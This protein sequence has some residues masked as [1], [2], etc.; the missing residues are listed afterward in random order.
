MISGNRILSLASILS[1]SLLLAACSGAPGEGEGV[2]VQTPIVTASQ[3]E[4]G[5]VVGDWIVI[6]GLSDPEA[7]NPVTSNDASASEIDGY[8]YETLTS[9]DVV[10]LKSIPWIADSLPRV[11][12]DGLSYEFSIR[13]DARFSD[14]E[15]VTAED[16]IFHL[17]TIKNP[18]ILKA[19]PIRGYYSRVDSASMIDG[20]PLKLRVVMAE[21]YYLGDQWA[22][23]LIAYPKHIWDPTN[24]SDRISFAD[25]NADSVTSDE[26]RKLIRQMADSIE[27]INKNF[28]PNYIVGSG[29]Y[30]LDEF[31]A[32]DRVALRRNPDY[33]NQEHRYG[34]NWPERVMWL[35]INDRNAALSALKAG[36]IDIV[37]QLDQV[38]FK[39]E[40]ER[41]PKNDLVPAQYEYPAYNYVGYNAD[42]KEKPFLGD[43]KVRLAFA[44]ALDREKMIDK[45]FFG[46]AVPVQSPIYRNR[47]EYDTTLPFIEYDLSETRRLLDEAGW[48]D[49]DGDGVRDKVVDGKKIKMEFNLQLN[50][51]NNARRQMAIIF[52]EALRQAGV[53]VNPS[54]LE[55]AVF[56]ERLDGHD[57]DA[58]IGGWAMG[59]NEGD[60]FQIWHSASSELG[61][62]N[63]ISFKNPRVDELIETI[64]GEFDYEKRR[65]MYKE[66]QAIIHAEQP[67]NFLVSELR[68]CGFSNRFNDVG[69]YAPRPCFNAGWW[70]VSE[71]DQ[72]YVTTSPN[73]S[74][75]LK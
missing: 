27:D 60:M 45:I 8:M 36:E 13:P 26:T 72:K 39:Y 44:H 2:E 57:F 68:V 71:E 5:G 67:Y 10:T 7:L 56:L 62:S 14:G 25:L 63:Y 47:P 66:I 17:K 51:G 75:A 74:V 20:D 35:T 21:P 49:T 70:W 30:I 34:K 46:N 41:F 11:S 4:S 3:G 32:Q 61:G 59:V 53:A 15:P 69:F 22:G 55:W 64:R 33:W 73:T 50:S 18:N 65:E 19:A 28:D 29:P 48:K 9:T 31:V 1:L 42:S 23:G 38:Q 24:L 58:V 37:P 6:H 40:K 43:P 52:S 12:P 16:F 54:T